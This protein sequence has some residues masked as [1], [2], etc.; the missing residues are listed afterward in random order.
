MKNPALA[1]IALLA[2]AACG[3]ET[4]A[5]QDSGQRSVEAPAQPGAEPAKLVAEVEPTPDPE[6][7]VDAVIA[8]KGE[9]GELS[10]PREALTSIFPMQDGEGDSWSVFIQ[11]EEEAAETF[12]T[13]TTKTSGEALSVIVDDMVVSAP[14]LEAPV[15]GG[16]FVFPVDN[17][18]AASKVVAALKGEEVV[19]TEVVAVSADDAL[20]ADG[21]DE[22][23]EVAE[24]DVA[25]EAA[26]DE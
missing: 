16:G 26:T 4:S 18:E 17:G 24:A 11:L 14:I 2:L 1:M 3:E 25:E 15:Y 12:Y 21:E 5:T 8:F 13:L 6:P 20:P 10:L 19:H 22:A 9:D 23:E 7:P